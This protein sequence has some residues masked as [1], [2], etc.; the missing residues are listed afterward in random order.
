[1]ARLEAKVGI[2]ALLRR[3]GNIALRDTPASVPYR[4][5]FVM[6]APQQLHLTFARRTNDD[7]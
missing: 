2:S 7:R 1:L 6:H 4:P 3:L 5:S